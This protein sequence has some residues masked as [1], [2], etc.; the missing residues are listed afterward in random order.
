L[1]EDPGVDLDRDASVPPEF[2][3]FVRDMRERGGAERP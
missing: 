1:F 2:R 3:G